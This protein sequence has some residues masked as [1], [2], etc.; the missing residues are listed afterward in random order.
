MKLLELQKRFTLLIAEL[1]G[2]AYSQGHALTFGEAWRPPE[3][4]ALYAKQGRGSK[5]SLHCVRLA[6]DLNLFKGSEYLAEAAAY[7][8]L[9]DWWKGLS[10]DEYKCRWGGDF[11][12]GDANHFSIEWEGRA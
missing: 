2:H 3:T 11:K 6:V 1:I 10:N 4:A 9:G 12:S 7:K 8:P 5:N